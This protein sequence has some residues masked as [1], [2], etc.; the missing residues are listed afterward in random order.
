M[1]V[2]SKALFPTVLQVLPS[3]HSGGVE[4]ATLDMVKGIAQNYPKAGNYVTSAGGPLVEEVC[5]Y[6]GQHITLPLNTKSPFQIYKN[7]QRLVDVIKSHDIQLIHARSR[8]PAW[9]ALK[10]ARRQNIPFITTYHGIYNSNNPLKSFYNSIMARGDKVIAISQY[11]ANHINTYYTHTYHSN[12]VV[13]PEGI[14]TDFFDPARIN[15]EQVRSLR[16]KWKVPLDHKLVLLPGRLTRWKGQVVLLNALRLLN[17]TDMT[18]VFLGDDQGR[19][20]YRQ[21]L[22]VLAKDLPVKFISA[23]DVMPIAYAASDIVLSCSTDPEAFGRVTAEALA[24]GRPYIGT[25]HGAT[26]EMCIEGQTGFLVAPGDSKALAE[27]IK[28]LFDAEISLASSARQHIVQNFSLDKMIK[29][30]LELYQN[31]V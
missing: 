28:H 9:S 17:R 22:E 6:G 7:T 29:Q 21:E 24:M 5:L 31:A 16:Q 10:A 23:C 8:A 26:P 15:P 30:T 2:K 1:K 12:V 18:V 4:R 20:G 13:I 19:H 14:D 3:L 11:V 27:K 25:N